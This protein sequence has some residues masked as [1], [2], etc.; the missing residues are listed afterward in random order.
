MQRRLFQGRVYASFLAAEESWSEG[1]CVVYWPP[2]AALDGGLM[3][4]SYGAAMEVDIDYERATTHTSSHM[5]GQ[6]EVVAARRS[7]HTPSNW[8]MGRPQVEALRI[9]IDDTLHSLSPKSVV[10]VQREWNLFILF[11][12]A[13]YIPTFFQALDGRAPFRGCRFADGVL[14]AEHAD[15]VDGLVQRHGVKPSDRYEILH[16][17]GVV[18]VLAVVGRAL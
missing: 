13:L 10:K 17:L 11:E 3:A 4:A 9:A 6:I 14:V 7:D 12:S 8:A 2:C 5:T 15:L 1:K 16:A 18:D